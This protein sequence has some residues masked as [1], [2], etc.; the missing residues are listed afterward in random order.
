MIFVACASL[1]SRK[2]QTLDKH[3]IQISFQAILK[4]RSKTFF[5]N[6]DLFCPNQ[7]VVRSADCRAALRMRPEVVRDFKGSNCS[8][9]YSYLLVLFLTKNLNI[10]FLNV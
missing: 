9:F 5:S 2:Q 6:F 7:N 10:D 3:S 1:L 8:G 4:F